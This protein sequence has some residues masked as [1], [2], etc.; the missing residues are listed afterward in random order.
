M[1]AP[2]QL[3]EHLRQEYSISLN[4][5]LKILFRRPHLNSPFHAQLNKISVL[6]AALAVGLSIPATR[7]ISEKEE[8]RRFQEDAAELITKD[9]EETKVLT[10]GPHDFVHATSEFKKEK[11]NR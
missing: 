1:N 5:F 7:V 9:M 2:I 4:A 10:L 3:G 6:E 8:L 11:W